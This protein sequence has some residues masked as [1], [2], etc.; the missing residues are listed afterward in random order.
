MTGPVAV[1]PT[2]LPQAPGLCLVN[3]KTHRIKGVMFLVFVLTECHKEVFT[4]Q[5]TAEGRE[6]MKW[7]KN[8]VFA[9]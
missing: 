3:M 7:H 5:T 1:S 8:T 9:E 4:S 6:D 2:P